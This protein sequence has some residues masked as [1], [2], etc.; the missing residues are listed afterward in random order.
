M[1]VIEKYKN[2]IAVVDTSAMLKSINLLDMLAEIFNRVVVPKVCAEE[3]SRIK[4]RER[5]AGLSSRAWQVSARLERHPEMMY[6]HV[7]NGGRNDQEII[8]IANQLGNVAGAQIC[9][10]TDDIDFSCQFDGVTLKVGDLVT[11]ITYARNAY[12][13]D[14][15]ATGDFNSL[16]L[17]DWSDYELSEDVNLN[18]VL[19]NG[20]TILIST[21]RSH[22]PR[23][24]A[25]LEYL[26]EQ[27]VNLDQTDSDRNFL[28]P[29]SHCVQISDYRAF[30]MLVEAGADYNKGSMNE[31]LNTS[32]RCRN[33]G[34]TPLMIACWHGRTDFV[35]LLCNQRGICVN[36]QD[37]N[38][39]AL[40]KCAIRGNLELYDYMLRRPGIDRYIRDRKNHTADWFA[41]NHD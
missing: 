8:A 38:Y 24:Y 37:S 32:I 10:V 20:W 11:E 25:K 36:Q 6:D 13:G 39:T 23:K 21:I 30:K 40:M 29:L 3:L 4:D 33:E 19:S 7:R 18:A 16:Y 2:M 26:I 34:N 17:E 27:G 28:T 1:N 41:R 12:A 22:D 5:R 15:R 9:I 31:T 14:P 35:E